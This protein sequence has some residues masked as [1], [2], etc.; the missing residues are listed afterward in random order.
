MTNKRTEHSSEAVQILPPQ[1]G[2]FTAYIRSCKPLIF[3]A[4]TAKAQREFLLPRGR[5]DSRAARAE[6]LK[7]DV[8]AEYRQSVYRHEGDDVRTRLAFPASAFKKAMADAALDLPNAK[9]AQIGRLVS[10][11]EPIYVYGVPKLFITPIRTADMRHTPDLRIRA[12]V[13][14]WALS[15]DIRYLTPNLTEG[16]VINLLN[17]A[18]AIIGVGDFRQQKGAGD[19]GQ[20]EVVNYSDAAYQ[21]LVHSCGREAQ[22]QALASPTFYDANSQALYEWYSEELTRTNRR[23]QLDTGANGAA[24]ANTF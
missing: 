24:P 7:H 23:A 20:F 14:E 11:A 12:I 13:K 4:L 10:V 18:G 5:R 6:A 21:Q 15:L 19:F 2:E 3:N 8:L 9:K 17:A 1:F 22:D 16:S